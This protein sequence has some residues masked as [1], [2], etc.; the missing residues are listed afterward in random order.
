VL[1]WVQHLLGV[2]HL[3]RIV[4]I[5]EA[6]AA[7]G[8]AVRVVSGGMP[9]PALAPAAVEVV[10]LPPVRSADARFSALADADGRPLDE[11]ARAR[12][13][14]RLLAE[15]AGF[16]PHA[17][18]LESFPFGRR[19][20][21]FEL[22][23]LLA[24]A[25]RLR[26]R[27][28][29]LTSVRDIVH[30]ARRP[31]RIRETAATILRDVDGVLVHGDPAFVRFEESFAAAREI[32]GRLRYTGFVAPPA[33]APGDRL[34]GRGEVVVSAG[35]GA[36]GEHLLRAALA[37]RAHARRAGGTWRLLAGPNLPAGRLA[38]L[39]AGAGDGVI[40]E[41]ARADFTALLARCAAS[42][43]QCGYNTVMDLLRVRAR[44]V[45]VPYR[46]EGE[47]E[48]A[49]RAERLAAHGL[50]RCLDE[51]A[52]TPQRLAAVV[53]AAAA[54]PAPEVGLDLD[55][56]ARSAAAIEEWIA[57]RPAGA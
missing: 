7:R 44:A 45:V 18:V 46:G 19:M 37:A 2:G 54:G 40:V 4:L 25:R 28:V 13:R 16:R 24:A 50:A 10:Q 36:V 27:P 3:R 38:A 11:A 43:S 55:G 49:L 5:A 53:D 23:P 22:E 6:A 1:F 39:R 21:R 42:V 47:T 48:Q 41:P 57:A 8:L 14:D 26:P 29:V 30:S 32:A 20:L 51:S 52:L 35:G 56:A 9:A 33:P 12:R 31:E 15:L 17:L 34:D